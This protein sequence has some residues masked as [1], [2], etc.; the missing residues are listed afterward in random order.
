MREPVKLSQADV[1]RC[2][3]GATHQADVVM[4]LYKLVY[5]DFDCIAKVDGFPKVS[6]DISDYIWTRMI[7]FD[8]KHH[9][10]VM[11]GGIWLDKGFS[12]DEELPPNTVIPAPV[13]LKERR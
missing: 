6:K 4:S 13:T 7:A 9:P 1:D 3:S 12:T 11:A 5:P 2:F 10:R 8:K